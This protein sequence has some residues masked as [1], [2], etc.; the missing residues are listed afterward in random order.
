MFD[1]KQ[2]AKELAIQIKQ[3]S[4]LAISGD[5]KKQA[6]IRFWDS[7]GLSKKIAQKISGKWT[8]WIPMKVK[9]WIINRARDMIIEMVYRGL[10][11]GLKS[12]QNA[13][14]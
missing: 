14:R 13:I 6:V 4:L 2:I 11:E 8:S 3:Q 1:F 12:A 5:I 9:I 10:K 7:Q